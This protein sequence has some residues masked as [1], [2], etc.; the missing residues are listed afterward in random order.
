MEYKET[1]QGLFGKPNLDLDY[2]PEWKR[3]DE[4]RPLKRTV[5]IFYK[6]SDKIIGKNED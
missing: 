2:I 6:E 5:R 1:D 4:L 3:Q